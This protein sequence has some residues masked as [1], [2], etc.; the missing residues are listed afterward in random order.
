VSDLDSAILE[1]GRVSPPLATALA[2]RP[3]LIDGAQPGDSVSARVLAALIRVALAEVLG[4]ADLETTTS[5]LSDAMDD[6]VG[7]ELRAAVA[8]VAER[9]PIAPEIGFAVIAM[10]KWGARELNYYSDIDLVFVHG[11]PTD[12]ETETRAAALAIAS[13]LISALSAPTFDGPTLNVDADLRPEGTMGP[14][15]RGLEGYSG[16]YER[17]GEAWELQA[18]LK[19]RPAAGDPDLGSRFREMADRIIWEEGLDVDA[20]RSIRSL[21]ARAEE[22]AKSTDIKRSRG[23]IRDI[24]FAVQILQLVHGRADDELR[25]TSTLGAIAALSRHGYIED[26]EAQRLAAAYRFLRN[27]EHRLQLRELRQTHTLPEEGAGREWLARAMGYGANPVSEF[28]QRLAEVRETVRDLH[29]RLYF[30]PILDALV[31]LSTARLTQAAATVRLEALGFRKTVA[32]S[33]AVND[34]MSGMSRRSAVMRQMLPLMLDWLS[35]SPDPD[36]G[37]AQLRLLLARSS[38]H[39]AL[40]RVLQT[41]PVAGE[42]L[43]T[44]LGTG[45]LVGELMDRIPEFVPRLADDALLARIRDL[46]DATTRLIG[47]LDSRPEREAGIGTIRRF[48]RRRKLRIAAR[49]ILGAAPPQATLNALSDSADAAVAGAFHMISEADD[50]FGII[51]MGRWGGRELSYGSDIDLMYVHG[52]KGKERGL[53]LAVEMGKVLSEPNRHGEAYQIDAGLRPEGRKGPLSRSLASYARYYEEWVEPWELLA[54]VKARPSAGDEELLGEYFEM[55]EPVVWRKS[56]SREVVN[57]IRAIKARVESE[58]IPANEDPDFHL[59]LGPGGLSDVEFATQFLQLSHGGS[60]PEIRVPGTFPALQALRDAGLLTS[61][62]FHDLY[63]AYLFCTRVRLR[64][65][66][67][68]GRPSDSLPMVH[69]AASRLAA[70]LGLERTGELREQYRRFTRRSRRTF[71]A[72]FYD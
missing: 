69:D 26:D 50:R 47:V 19:A 68:S 34:L 37:L 18:L 5:S 25:V 57:E 55:I 16:Y 61:S 52:P 29:E 43:C 31:G 10:G 65:H 8:H 20:L 35:Q 27:V 14:L 41:N 67:Q 23:G 3:D 13:R 17:W 7:D 53:H 11:G 40:I 44:L 42:R 30:R 66:L 38:D 33:Q 21:K 1:L 54:L 56:L 28:D 36:L 9:H 71:E 48:V 4:T 63:D 51:A 6:I 2:K 45:R 72:I 32:A 64:L 24:E 12:R 59:K 46:G 39:A 15:S 58:R 70:S 49:D 60:I 22:G 62:Q